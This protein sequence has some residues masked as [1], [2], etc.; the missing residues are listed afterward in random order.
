MK[1]A[2][3]W[4]VLAA[5]IIAPVNGFANGR[6]GGEDQCIKEMYFHKVMFL[7]SQKE[8]L[9]LKDEQVQAIKD[10]RY[11]IKK[12]LIEGEPQLKLAMLDMKEELRKDKVNMDRLNALID[13]K[14]EAKK[15]LAKA[16]LKAMVDTMSLLTPEQRATLQD[17]CWKMKKGKP[18]G[19]KMCGMGKGRS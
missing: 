6:G 14:M 3:L 5:I 2:I 15:T 19:M 9:D 17:L 13:V 18:Y 7:L 10:I 16:V 11:E 1:R 4:M 8:E 12:K